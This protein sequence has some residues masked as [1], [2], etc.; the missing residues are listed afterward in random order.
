MRLARYL[1]VLVC[2]LAAGAASAQGYPSKPV[3]LIIG[4]GPGT[5]SDILGRFLGTQLSEALGQAVVVENRAGAGGIIGSDSVAK[6]A[7]DGYTLLLGTN[8]MLI[9]SPLLAKVPPYHIEKDFVPVAG[10]A[11]TA[12]AMVT[13]TTPE[14]P[15]TLP[16]LIAKAKSGNANY[17]SAGQGTIGHLASEIAVRA[18]GVKATHIPYKGSGQSLTDVARGEVLFAT[19]TLAAALPHVRAGRLRAVAVT[20]ESRIAS[21]AD[22]PTF[23]ESGVKGVNVYAWWGIFAP[24]GTPQEPVRRL[25]Q[26]IAAVMADADMRKRLAGMEIEPHPMTSARLAEFIKSEF[27]FWQRFLAE[28]GIRLD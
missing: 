6:A 19:D 1:L 26:A 12:F 4:F 27:P 14:S 17:A 3:K 23:T 5:G 25:E 9:T 8:A 20:G 18:M 10:V 16:E 7:P 2:A 11:R 21:L 13:G 24:A 15:K 28:S 22:T